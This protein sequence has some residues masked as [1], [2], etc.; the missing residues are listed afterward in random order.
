M[1]CSASWGDLGRVLGPLDRLLSPLPPP[2]A[3]DQSTGRMLSTPFSTPYRTSTSLNLTPLNSTQLTSL[4]DPPRPPFWSLLGIQIDPRSPQVASWHLTFA[5]T[6]LFTKHNVFPCQIAKNDPKTAPKTTQDRPK[7]APRRS[8]RAS[9]FIFVFDIDFG[10]S[11]VPFWR[12]LGSLLGTQNWP[13]SSGHRAS[14]SLK[15]P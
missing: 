7:T 12:H 14:L 1:P 9:F 3:L 15:R 11:W 5:K 2:P 8:S 4:F 13:K 10:P 6:S